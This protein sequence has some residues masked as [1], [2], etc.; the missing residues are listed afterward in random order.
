MEGY[1]GDSTKAI[2]PAVRTSSTAL[3]TCA[4]RD[5]D[6]YLWYIGRADDVFKSSDY[7]ISPFKLE[8]VAIG[9]SGDRRGGSG[10]QP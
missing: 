5:S 8:S 3:A 4:R 6:G 2:A 1:S 10:A 7:R 9:T